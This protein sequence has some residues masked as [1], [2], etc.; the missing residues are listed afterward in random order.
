MYQLMKVCKD[1]SVHQSGKTQPKL[2]RCKTRL[3]KMNKGWIVQ[4]KGDGR[5]V[6]VCARGFNRELRQNIGS[7]GVMLC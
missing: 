4:L 5:K 1:G 2:S 6:V 3:S 7:V